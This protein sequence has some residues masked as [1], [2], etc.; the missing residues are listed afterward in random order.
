MATFNGEL[1]IEEQLNSILHQLGNNDEVIISDDGSK[2]KTIDIVKS[3]KDPRIKIFHSTFHNVIQNFENTLYKASGDIIFLSDQDDIWYPNKVKESLKILQNNDLVFSNL[4]VF[5]STKNDNYTMFDFR[6]NYNGIGRN[7]I[8]NHCVGATMGFKSHLLKYALPF[9]KNI[10]MH[11]MWIFFISSFY[12]KAYY[13]N[14]PLIY[15]RRHGLN[16]S[17]TGGKTTNSLFKI[18]E[19]R[20]V[21]IISLLRRIVKI[22]FSK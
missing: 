8:K 20:I 7:F 12:G 16:V 10:E 21:W 1:Y 6:K 11:D 2:D 19:I 3:F 5:S 13:Y 17:N 9:P 18:L 15:Y 4:S 22:A 14:Q